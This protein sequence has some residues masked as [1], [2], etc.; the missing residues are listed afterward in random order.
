MVTL[1]EIKLKPFSKYKRQRKS[2]RDSRISSKK[3]YLVKIYGRW[4]AGTFSK[5]WYGWSFNNWGFSGIQLDSIDGPL[6]LIE[7]KLNDNQKHEKQKAFH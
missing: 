7:E 2:S 6:Y 1:K 3:S 5:Q 4:Y